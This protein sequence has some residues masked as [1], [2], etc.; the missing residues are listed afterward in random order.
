M[1]VRLL[2]RFKRKGGASQS[3]ENGLP[4]KRS[5]QESRGKR[6]YRRHQAPFPQTAL[7]IL[8]RLFRWR[9]HGESGVLLMLQGP[10]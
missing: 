8:S 5:L 6:G 7:L 1:K 2:L 10:L 4:L 3:P 9:L